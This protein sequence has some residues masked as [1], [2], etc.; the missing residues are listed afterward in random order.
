M[1]DGGNPF[2]LPG[3]PGGGTGP[4]VPPVPESTEAPLESGTRRVPRMDPP[5]PPP[6]EPAPPTDPSPVVSAPAPTSWPTSIVPPGTIWKLVLPGG[7]EVPIDAPVL[8]GR[9]P[10]A[11]DGVTGAHPIPVRDPEKTVSKTHV[12]LQPDPAG[13]RVRDLFSTNGTTIVLAA[14]RIPVPAEGDVLVAQPAD[15]ELGRYVVRLEP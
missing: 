12:I 6:S 13:V 4:A 2:L 7:A 15:L 5:P 10:E 14:G 1:A 3:A 9:D 8:L 11:P